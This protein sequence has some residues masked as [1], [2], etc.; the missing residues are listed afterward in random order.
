MWLDTQTGVEAWFPRRCYWEV[1][2]SWD[3]ALRTRFSL[4]CF[5]EFSISEPNPEAVT[6][7]Q[8]L[9]SETVGVPH[10]YLLVF[11]LPPWGPSP[12][13]PPI[14]NL[15]AFH[16]MNPTPSCIYKW[17]KGRSSIQRKWVWTPQEQHLCASLITKAERQ[18]CSFHDT[19]ENNPSQS[20]LS[21]E[22]GEERGNDKQVFS[23][24]CLRKVL[25]VSYLGRAQGLP[26]TAT[27]KH[28]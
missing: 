18:P 21:W 20:P 22:L 23:S 27:Q 26:V 25:K 11:C 24:I 3:R 12:D 19:S 5:S 4:A 6:W 16:S 28:W 8:L 9:W 7:A 15:L 1:V 10:W 17:P 2:G 14:W 13:V